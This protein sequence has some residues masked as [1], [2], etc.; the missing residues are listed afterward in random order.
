MMDP[1]KGEIK[2]GKN[3]VP[4]YALIGGTFGHVLYGDKIDPSKAPIQ[5]NT[6]NGAELDGKIW[7]VKIMKGKQLYDTEEKTLIV[8]KLFGPK[9]SGAYLSDGDWQKAASAGM[10]TAGL[11][12]SG[13]FGWVTTE[14]TI[15]VN[16]QV[17]P[18][19]KSLK[20][21]ACHS[22]DGRL[23]NVKAGWVPGRDRSL[24]LDIVGI[25]AL[26]GSLGGASMHGYMR[27]KSSAKKGE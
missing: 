23:E 5:L 24:F 3:V 16:H 19:D 21:E 8:P 11:N 13:K 10:S 18:K 17:L 2:Y 9:G 12:F 15:P 14:M 26:L 27:Y 4:D 20:C 6:F 7:P 25:L 22:R 1:K